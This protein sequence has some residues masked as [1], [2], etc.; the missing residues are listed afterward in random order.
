MSSIVGEQIFEYD[1]E[2][3]NAT[4]PPQ[5]NLHA[6]RDALKATTVDND[7]SLTSASID[8]VNGFEYFSGRLYIGMSNEYSIADRIEQRV[9]SP[10][11]RI[12]RLRSELAVLVMD[13]DLIAK[14]GGNGVESCW[15]SLQK[16]ALRLANIAEHIPSHDSSSDVLQV[17]DLQAKM[18]HAHSTSG[19]STTSRLTSGGSQSFVN[20]LHGIQVDNLGVQLDLRLTA[21]EAAVGARS[22][23]AGSSSLRQAIERLEHRVSVLD[24]SSLEQLKTRLGAWRVEWENINGGS[25]KRSQGESKLL[26]SIARLEELHEG[27]Q[28]VLSCAEA[29]PILVL[30][31]QSLQAAHA[32]IGSCAQQV[33]SM[34][35]RL[36]AVEVELSANKAAMSLLEQG[37]SQ[38]MIDIS[39]SMSEVSKTATPY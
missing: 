26:E 21:V 9:E 8:A 1:G 22:I 18:R 5:A 36:G 35:Q 23:G 17:D 24:G 28:R 31:L 38:N 15:Q 2:S 32:T 3:I 7:D 14:D 33:E 19:E 4:T 29:L 11:Q 13:L 30:R 25:G 6:F 16:E 37:L 34:E 10:Q 12:Q 39:A 27:V 20:S